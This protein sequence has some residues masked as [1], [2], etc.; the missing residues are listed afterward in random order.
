MQRAGI[1]GPSQLGLDAGND[2]RRGGFGLESAAGPTAQQLVDFLHAG[3]MGKG[4]GHQ[5]EK[6]IPGYNLIKPAGANAATN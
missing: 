2:M 1:F 6:A 3:A 5:I 4:I